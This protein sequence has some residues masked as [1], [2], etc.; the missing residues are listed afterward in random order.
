M[1]SVKTQKLYTGQF[2]LGKHGLWIKEGFLMD[3]PGIL[4]VLGPAW[5]RDGTLGSF[6][7]P[8][9]PCLGLPER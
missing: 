2:L 8:V 3:P 6:R 7:N 4:G 9:G 1:R 5:N